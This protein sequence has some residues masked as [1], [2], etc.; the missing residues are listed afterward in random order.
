MHDARVPQVGGKLFHTLACRVTSQS[1]SWKPFYMPIRHHQVLMTNLFCPASPSFL[2]CA[3]FLNWR[4]QLGHWFVDDMGSPLCEWLNTLS[5]ELWMLCY[6]SGHHHH[7][8]SLEGIQSVKQCCFSKMLSP[9]CDHWSYME[10]L[11]PI[12]IRSQQ[13]PICIDGQKT[14]ERV[15][16]SRYPI[17]QKSQPLKL[18]LVASCSFV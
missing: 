11:L 5:K 8:L 7:W 10:L 18:D 4:S 1:G 9:P 16:W 6:K 2:I 15:P 3:L 13:Q 14:G 17:R 12:S